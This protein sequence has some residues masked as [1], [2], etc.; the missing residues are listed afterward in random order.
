MDYRSHAVN[1]V[2]AR[3]REELDQISNVRKEDRIIITGLTNSIP[4]PADPAQ[5][6]AWAKTMVVDILKRLDPGPREGRRR[7]FVKLES[8]NNR[9]IPMVE[10][11]L[12]SRETALD[13]RGKFVKLKKDLA[14]LGSL[15]LANCVTL[16]TRVRADILRALAVILNNG[17]K[18]YFVS[19]YNSRPVLH[20]NA[21]SRDNQARTLTFT[22]AVEKLGHLLSKLMRILRKYTWTA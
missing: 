21:G 6:I 5:R 22:D 13:V 12:D 4:M 7:L 2:M 9:A 19:S 17:G 1:L 3:L 8:N 18:D 14:D 16:A 10:V 20:C 11:K 15:H